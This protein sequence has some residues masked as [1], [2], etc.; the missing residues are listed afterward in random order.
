MNSR[1]L[2][3]ISR[4]A[5]VTPRRLPRPVTR[6][7]SPANERGVALVIT[8]ILLAVI[9]FMAVTFLVISNSQKAAAGTAQQQTVAHNAV[10]A[11]EERFVADLAARI[12][13][14]SNAYTAGIFVS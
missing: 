9:T 8:L 4:L 1:R 14:T 2:N 3:L 7:P 12:F 10:A 13:A 6:H 11:A 5:C